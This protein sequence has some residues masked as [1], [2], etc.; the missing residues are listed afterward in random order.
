MLDVVLWQVGGGG[1]ESWVP[2]SLLPVINMLGSSSSPLRSFRWFS[3]RISKGFMATDVTARGL[4]SF[5]PVAGGYLETGMT[6]VKM[7]VS[8]SAQIFRL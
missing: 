6:Q 5:N 4:W 8:W 3:I 7:G 2:G 1:T